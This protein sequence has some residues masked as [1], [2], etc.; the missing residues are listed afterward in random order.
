MGN[1]LVAVYCFGNRKV[2]IY[3]CWDK[4]TKENEFDFFDLYENNVCLNEGDPFHELPTR[5]QVRIF[6]VD[7]EAV[8]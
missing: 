1:E 2:E 3:G 4:E 7:R 5:E 6:L 8:A